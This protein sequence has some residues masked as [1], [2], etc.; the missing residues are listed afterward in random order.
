M[1]KVDLIL[2]EKPFLKNLRVGHL[3][4]KEIEI[5]A[6][7]T[8]VESHLEKEGNFQILLYALR[9]IEVYYNIILD[10]IFSSN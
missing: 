9:L 7:E 4:Q 5:R 2:V 1:I 6:E 8:R 3:L 10:V